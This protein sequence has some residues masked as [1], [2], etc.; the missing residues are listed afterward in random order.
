MQTLL[1]PKLVILILSSLFFSILYMFL[2]DNHFSG[3]NFVKETI[4]QEVIK[5]KIHT[6]MKNQPELVTETLPQGSES[7]SYNSRNTY[8][9]YS[10]QKQTDDAIAGATKSV[11]T[12]VKTDDLAAENINVS[13]YQRMFDRVYFSL[14]TSCLLGYG[15]IYPL[16][17][18]AKTITM[19][20]A[21]VTVSLIVI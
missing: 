20:Q 19:V 7:S 17:N 10:Q 8:T 14:N 1:Q 9:N 18:T 4:K 3:V 5:Q 11:S 13:V 2:D 12:D 15:D 6:E 16:S 21:L